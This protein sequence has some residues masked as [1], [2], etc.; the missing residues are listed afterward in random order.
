[1]KIICGGGLYI[2]PQCTV[3]RIDEKYVARILNASPQSG[4]QDCSEIRN[5]RGVRGIG[6]LGEALQVV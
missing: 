5:K 2:R 1:M 6:L 4:N 3:V